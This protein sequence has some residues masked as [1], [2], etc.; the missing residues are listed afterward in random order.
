MPHLSEQKQELRQAILER[1]RHMNEQARAAESRSI[2]R[3]LFGVLPQDR[4]VCAFFPLQTEPDIRPLLS[5]II[6]RDQ[7]LFLP[8]FDGHMLVMRRTR[9][10]AQLQT[11]TFGIPEPPGDAEALDVHAPVIALIPGRAFDRTGGRLGRG[12]GGYD[13]WMN[14]HRKENGQSLYYGV[15]FDCQLVSEVPMEEHDVVLDG[16]ITGRGFASQRK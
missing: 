14:A 4:A 15:A 16:M 5:A 7:P 8:A 3:Q 6:T 9:D 13:R 10:L 1:I 2:V 12:N 11:S